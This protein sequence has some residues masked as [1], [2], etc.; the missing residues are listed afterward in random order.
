MN[1][2]KIAMDP[3]Q[4]EPGAGMGALRRMSAQAVIQAK[5]KR[6][7][8]EIRSLEVILNSIPWKVLSHPDEENLWR[9]FS[10]IR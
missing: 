2:E 7:E 10:Q 9:Y 6:L 1:G 4:G 8:N 3:K 5:I